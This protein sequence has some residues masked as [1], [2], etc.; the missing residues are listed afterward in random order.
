MKGTEVIIFLLFFLNTYNDV[1]GLL[2]FIAIVESP[3]L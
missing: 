1:C 3:Y 2:D